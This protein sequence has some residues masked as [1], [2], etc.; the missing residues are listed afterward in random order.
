M[1]YEDE[2]IK[3]IKQIKEENYLKYLYTLVKELLGLE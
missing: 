3:M 1:S 2:I